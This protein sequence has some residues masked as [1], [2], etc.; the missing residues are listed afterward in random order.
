[1]GRSP[2]KNDFAAEVQLKTCKG[3]FLRGRSP[4]EHAASLLRIS[5]TKNIWGL[6]GR[7]PLITFLLLFFQKS[8]IIKKSQGFGDSMSPTMGFVRGEAPC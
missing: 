8:K 5:G 1:M 3:G 6:R 2:I 7:S 4:L